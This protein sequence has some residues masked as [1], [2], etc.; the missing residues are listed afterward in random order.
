M[1]FE[2][3][4]HHDTS[5]VEAMLDS[6]CIFVVTAIGQPHMLHGGFYAMFEKRHDG[7]INVRDIVAVS[8]QVFLNQIARVEIKQIILLVRLLLQKNERI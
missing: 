4:P 7:N 2:G 5:V 3:F 6:D 8:S 1:L